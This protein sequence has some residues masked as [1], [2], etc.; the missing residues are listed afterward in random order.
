VEPWYDQD[1]LLGS[2]YKF[3]GGR[4]KGKRLVVR[5]PKPPDNDDVG[6]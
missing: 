4:R 1:L 3:E 5:P 6:V 2:A